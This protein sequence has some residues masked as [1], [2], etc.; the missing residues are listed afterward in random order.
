MKIYWVFGW[1][2]FYP[3]GGLRNLLRT[4][5]TWVEANDY[6]V[7]VAAKKWDH[8]QLVNIEKHLGIEKR[9]SNNED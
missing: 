3:N 6:R 2:Q 4:F 5:D 8:T 9:D 7:D 1:D